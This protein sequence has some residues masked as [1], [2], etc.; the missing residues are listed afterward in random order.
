MDP[1]DPLNINYDFQKLNNM[2]IHSLRAW[3]PF[4]L[5]DH[6]RGTRTWNN[7]IRTRRRSLH[8]T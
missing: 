1:I 7:L 8:C 6:T 4:D 2:T 5:W 3:T